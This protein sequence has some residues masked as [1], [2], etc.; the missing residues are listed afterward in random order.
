LAKVKAP[1]VAVSE[2]S[3]QGSRGEADREDERSAEGDDAQRSL[4]SPLQEGG[5][6]EWEG[7]VADD[8]ERAGR[9]GQGCGEAVGCRIARQPR[10]GGQPAQRDAGQHGAEDQRERHRVIEDEEREEAEPDHLQREQGEARQ[11]GG[12]QGPARAAPERRARRG[13][14]HDGPGAPPREPGCD[15]RGR[16]VERPRCEGR[17]AHPEGVDQVGLGRHHTHQRAEGVPAVEPSEH[18]TEVGI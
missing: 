9:P 10:R 14:G 16:E 12:G 1:V 2:R 18:A 11:E 3:F 8:A 4:E 5:E 7:P 6:E 15:Q 13:L 17:A